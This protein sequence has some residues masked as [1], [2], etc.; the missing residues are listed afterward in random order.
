M[1]RIALLHIVVEQVY[2]SSNNARF[3]FRGSITAAVKQE[4]PGHHDGGEIG[5]LVGLVDVLA[6]LSTVSAYRWARHV[7]SARWLSG[8]LD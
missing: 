8:S 7:S 4:H 6:I 1:Q 3:T 5:G 2:C